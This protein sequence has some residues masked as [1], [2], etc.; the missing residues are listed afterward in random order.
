MIINFCVC[1]ADIADSQSRIKRTGK[2][3]RQLST[4]LSD[5][6]LAISVIHFV[7][8][9]FFTNFFAALGLGIQGA[10]A[11]AGTVRFSMS[12]PDRIIKV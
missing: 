3:P 5:A 10:A 1:T 4:V 6:V 8:N 2:M 7:Y 11:L 9:V 12:D